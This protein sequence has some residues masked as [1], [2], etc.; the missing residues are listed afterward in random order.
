MEKVGRE[1]RKVDKGRREERIYSD[2]KG[3]E[4]DLIF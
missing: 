4:E 3:R 2:I 1:G